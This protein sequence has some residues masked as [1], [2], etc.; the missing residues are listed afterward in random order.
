MQRKIIMLEAAEN[1]SK[2]VANNYKKKLQ[3]LETSQELAISL[4]QVQAD[5]I[6]KREKALD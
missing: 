2:R 6:E 3:K 4:M 5:E 1:K